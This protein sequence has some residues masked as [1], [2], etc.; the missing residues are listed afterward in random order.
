MPKKATSKRSSQQVGRRAKRR[1]AGPPSSRKRPVHA[2]QTASIVG[3]SLAAMRFK[4]KSGTEV[5]FAV[6]GLDGDDAER[7]YG[8]IYKGYT[9]LYELLRKERMAFDPLKKGLSYPVA[10]GWLLRQIKT[11]VPAEFDFNIDSEEN[12]SG[13]HLTIF[14]ECYWP[15]QFLALECGPALLK[16]GKVNRPLQALFMSF[17]RTFGGATSIDIWTA[18]MM[19]NS[20]EMLDDNMLQMEGDRDPQDLEEMGIEIKAHRSGIPYKLS[21]QIRKA[22]LMSPDEL[23]RRAKRY[24]AGNPIANLIHQGA[25]LLREGCSLMDYTYWSSPEDMYHNACLLLLDQA[26]FVWEFNT[27]L[28]NEHEEYLDCQA[29]EGVQQPIVSATIDRATKSL[30]MKALSKKADWP[31]RLVDFFSRAYELTEKFKQA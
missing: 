28:M 10:L 26:S 16:L 5:F 1:A 17:I 25:E 23:Q 29:Q 15:N 21:K 18:G 14:K 12:G 27:H 4:P 3:D 22:P 19:G 24:K 9:R 31:T 11:L 7:I 13:C 8:D 20:L 6:G 30:D 2:P